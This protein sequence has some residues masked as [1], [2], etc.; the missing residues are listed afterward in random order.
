MLASIY[1]YHWHILRTI[2]AM[3][4]LMDDNAE[5]AFPKDSLEIVKEWLESDDGTIGVCLLCGKRIVSESDL[6][7]GTNQ[8]RCATI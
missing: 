2:I 5:I 3:E 1:K 8:H 7:P 6:V 4:S